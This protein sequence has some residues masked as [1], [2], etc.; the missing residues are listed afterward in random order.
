MGCCLA[1]VLEQGL[2]DL[3]EDDVEAMLRFANA[4]TTLVISKKGALLCR[5]NKEDVYV[6]QDSR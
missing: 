2:N 3:D 1:F 5:P 4:V 6:R